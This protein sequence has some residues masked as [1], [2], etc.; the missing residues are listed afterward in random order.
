MTRHRS[1]ADALLDDFLP[2]ELKSQ[3][4]ARPKKP[5]LPAGAVV[6]C[7]GGHRVGVVAGDIPRVGDT[8]RPMP[9]PLLHLE[10]DQPWMAHG[11]VITAEVDGVLMVVGEAPDRPRHEVDLH[12]LYDAWRCAR[13]D[14]GYG[15]LRTRLLSHRVLQGRC[16]LCGSPY[17]RFKLRRGGTVPWT[18]QLH[19][20][21]GWR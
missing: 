8:V 11:G 18:W 3:R 12:I 19:T 10:D 6:T 21:A 7:G 14:E 13:G 16:A 15:E 20:E 1:L 4:A 9:V 5:Y 2:D 17:F